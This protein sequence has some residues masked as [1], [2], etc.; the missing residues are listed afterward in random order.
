[1]L[2]NILSE[3]LSIFRD[4][5]ILETGSFFTRQLL[6]LNNVTVMLHLCEHDTVP[7]AYVCSSP[8]MGCEINRLGCSAHEDY[9]GRILSVDEMGDFSPGVF[10]CYSRF[11]AYP[12]DSSV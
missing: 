4:S 10:I 6:P 12:V 5:D 3:E 9:L 7:E 2:M 8:G 1:M 11:F